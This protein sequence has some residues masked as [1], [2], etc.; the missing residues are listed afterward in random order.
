MPQYS[1][2]RQT[3]DVGNGITKNVIRVRA[4]TDLVMGAY[5]ETLVPNW[6]KDVALISVVDENGNSLFIP[7]SA[8]IPYLINDIYD[9]S[10]NEFILLDNGATTLTITAQGPKC[11]NS[12]TVTVQ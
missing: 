5:G 3:I 10:S 9:F 12:V 2:I 1:A 7:K 11:F 6:G 8:Q 4:V